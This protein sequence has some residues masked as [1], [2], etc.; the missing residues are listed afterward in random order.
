M[1]S[2]GCGGSNELTR[3]RDAWRSP[4]GRHE[5]DDVMRPVLLHCRTPRAF[6]YSPQAEQNGIAET[7]ARKGAQ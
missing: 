6:R 1:T 7:A 4:S 5:L 2:V 3:L